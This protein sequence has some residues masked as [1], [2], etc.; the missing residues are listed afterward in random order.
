MR[1]LHETVKGIGSIHQNDVTV[2][3]SRLSGRMNNST[4]VDRNVS[5][6]VDVIHYIHE[7]L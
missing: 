5:I 4:K 7:R 3:P 6:L 1:F 2:T